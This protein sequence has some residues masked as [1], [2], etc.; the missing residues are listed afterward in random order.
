MLLGP[1]LS[2][3]VAPHAIRELRA[4]NGAN[5]FWW[6]FLTLCHCGG[7]IPNVDGDPGGDGC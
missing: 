3:I 7:C 2:V 5:N 1:E 6:Y 4:T